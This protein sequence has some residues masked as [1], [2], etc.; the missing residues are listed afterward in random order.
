MNHVSITTLL[1]LRVGI[2]GMYPRG[3]M[4]TRARYLIF[5]D[6]ILKA[7]RAR[8]FCVNRM[9]QDQSLRRNGLET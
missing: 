6:L 1:F 8:V 2:Y 9:W 3:I 7:S 4:E 5:Q